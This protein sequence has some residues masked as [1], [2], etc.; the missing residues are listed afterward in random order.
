MNTKESLIQLVDRFQQL[1]TDGGLNKSSE[2]TMRAWRD[3]FL[4]IFGWD[5]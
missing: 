3:E 4:A 2:A 1:K 5:V